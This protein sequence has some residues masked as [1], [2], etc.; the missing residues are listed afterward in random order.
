MTPVPLADGDTDRDS[1]AERVHDSM[2]I[3][4]A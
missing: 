4:G 3:P 2:S 1:R